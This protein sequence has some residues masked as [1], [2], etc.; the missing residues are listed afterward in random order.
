MGY[1]VDICSTQFLRR[2]KLKI[3]PYAKESSYKLFQ[4]FE[5]DADKVLDKVLSLPT[6]K[7]MMKGI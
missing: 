5:S 7:S 4:K 2:K 1:T 3:A 6:L